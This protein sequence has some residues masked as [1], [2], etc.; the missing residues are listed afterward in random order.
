MDDKSNNLNEQLKIHGQAI[1]KSMSVVS[2]TVKQAIADINA[3]FEE[4]QRRIEEMQRLADF[5][6]GKPPSGIA[7]QHIGIVHGGEYVIS[8][9]DHKAKRELLDN[10]YEGK[11]VIRSMGVDDDLVV[12]IN[13]PN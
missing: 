10:H 1:Q 2:D 6:A 12:T 7:T 5:V 11:Y 13:V 9:A 3:G 4:A 8:Q